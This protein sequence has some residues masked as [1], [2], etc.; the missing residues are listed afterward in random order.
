MN[1]PYTL[2]AVLSSSK[3]CGVNSQEIGMLLLT[4]FA[5]LNDLEELRWHIC[6]LKSFAFARFAFA[7]AAVSALPAGAWR[8]LA[9]VA[10]HGESCGG[11]HHRENYCRRRVHATTAFLPG[12]NIIHRHQRSS[13]MAMPVHTPN[14]P[15][16]THTPIW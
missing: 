3:W 1:V 6:N 7:A 12:R 4:V 13:A 14:P 16:D 15:P 11:K 2:Y 10:P 9:D 8:T 5:M